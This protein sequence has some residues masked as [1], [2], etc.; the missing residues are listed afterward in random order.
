MSDSNST[1]LECLAFSPRAANSTIYACPWWLYALL[2]AI[3]G[4]TVT[5]CLI[6]L[7]CKCLRRLIFPYRDRKHYVRPSASGETLEEAQLR[8][9]NWTSPGGTPRS[10]STSSTPREND[11]SPNGQGPPGDAATKHWERF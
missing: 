2:G 1:S 5:T 8:E 10:A 9:R 7:Y 3:V 6:L 11:A 4:A